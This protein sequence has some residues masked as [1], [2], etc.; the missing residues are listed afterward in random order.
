[1]FSDGE[2]YAARNYSDASV[3]VGI[4]RTE[5]PDEENGTFYEVDV[6]LGGVQ[7]PVSCTVISRFSNFYNYEEIRL[8]PWL[9]APNVDGFLPPGSAG[10]YHFRDGEVVLIAFLDGDSREGV[11]LG[12]IKH[13]VRA[14]ATEPDT[15]A[16]YSTYNGLETQIDVD[17]AYTV[18]FQGTPLNRDLPV[19]PGQSEPV[20]P[21][22]DPTIAGSFF[23]F[24]ATGSFIIDCKDPVGDNKIEIT[25]AAGGGTMTITSGANVISLAGNPAQGEMTVT[26]GNLTLET[27]ATNITAQT[28]FAVDRRAVRCPATDIRR[29]WPGYSNQSSRNLYSSYGLSTVA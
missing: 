16:Y 9:R 14:A 21:Q 29:N 20:E 19:P 15:L 22:Y 25:R 7:V 13:P 4:V 17:G 12:S 18:T 2:N 5:S 27:F 8:R 3:R 6:W 23:G 1:M 10:K 24:D 28:E 11:I 26:T